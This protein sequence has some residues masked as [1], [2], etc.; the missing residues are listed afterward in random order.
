[1]PRASKKRPKINPDGIYVAWESAA[2]SVPD[3]VVQRGERRRGSDPAVV[4]N[5]WLFVPR[6][7][8]QNE[9]P[10]E[11]DAEVAQT[12]AQAPQYDILLAVQP[13]PFE[14]Q[15]VTLTRPLRVAVGSTFDGHPERTVEL[16]AGERFLSTD[17]VVTAAP[18]D[19]FEREPGK[20]GL[21]LKS[22]RR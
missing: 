16:Q 13:L 19:C 14:D 11:F 10:S 9:W 1:M 2:L 7:L 22:G 15:V 18:P 20:P 5:P 3:E 21:S 12:D 8:P 4:E 17:P 6:D